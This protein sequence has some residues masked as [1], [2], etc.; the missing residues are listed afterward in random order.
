M[1]PFVLP[2]TDNFCRNSSHNR[3]WWNIFC[4]NSSSPDN[5]TLTDCD[6][7]KNN[8][9]RADENIV[10]DYYR[11]VSMICKIIGVCVVLC[12]IYHDISGN[13]NI[14]ANVKGS[15]TIKD[16]VFSNNAVHSY[17]NAFWHVESGTHVYRGA[18]ANLDASQSIKKPSNMVRRE[19]SD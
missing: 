2:L 9:P 11:S 3:K 8:S 7:W 19:C 6:R 14:V 15:S 17:R 4:Y 12:I 10:V 13:I 16:N 1:Q 18:F 5:C